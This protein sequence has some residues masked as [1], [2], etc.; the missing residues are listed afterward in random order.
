[1]KSAATV[2]AADAAR[3]PIMLT[4]LRLPTMKRA[5][6]GLAEQ[7]NREGWP[8]ERFLGVLL[9]QEMNE[10]ASRATKIVSIGPYRNSTKAAKN[11]ASGQNPGVRPLRRAAPIRAP[12]GC[13]PAGS[14]PR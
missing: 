8:A 3:L 14:A 13:Q 9:E 6:E 4:E 12:A 10:R 1:M 5:W 2:A 7:S 11:I